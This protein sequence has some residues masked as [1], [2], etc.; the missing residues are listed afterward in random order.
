MFMDFNDFNNDVSPEAKY[1]INT[2]KGYVI[3]DIY[4]GIEYT[5]NWTEATT[6]SEVDLLYNKK[7]IE[8]SLLEFYNTEFIGFVPI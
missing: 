6:F 8:E 1:V 5:D 3:G 7:A 4:Q 2:N